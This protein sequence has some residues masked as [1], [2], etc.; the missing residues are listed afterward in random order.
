MAGR[1][2][3]LQRWKKPRNFNDLPDYDRFATAYPA[4]IE[5]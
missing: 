1:L 2:A 4:N 5:D 3:A